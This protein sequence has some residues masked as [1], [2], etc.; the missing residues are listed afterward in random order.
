M[1]VPVATVLVAVRSVVVMGVDEVAVPT[2]GD[3]GCQPP[4]RFNPSG[5]ARRRTPMA[6]GARITK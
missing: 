4:G 5:S 3:T 6:K 2:G 1:P